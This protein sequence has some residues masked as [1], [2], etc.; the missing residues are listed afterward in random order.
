M[1][2]WPERFDSHSHRP[3]ELPVPS[4]THSHTPRHPPGPQ[5]ARITLSDRMGDYGGLNLNNANL[6]ADSSSSDE[7]LHPS[8]PTRPRHG[9]SMSQPFPSLFS[10][11]LRKAKQSLGGGGDD[12]DSDQ[13][14]MPKHKKPAGF[15]GHRPQASKDFATGHCMTCGSLVR[16][17]RELQVFKCTI[18]L[19]INDL[20]P[21]SGAGP[22]K[23]ASQRIPERAPQTGRERSGSILTDHAAGAPIS[24]EHTRSLIAECLQSYFRSALDDTEQGL[25]FQDSAVAAA[26]YSPEPTESPRVPAASLAVRPKP[27]G[28]STTGSPLT[29]DPSADPTLHPNPLRKVSMARSLS[30]SYPERRPSLHELAVHHN[31]RPQRR[32]DSPDSQAKHMFKQLEVYAAS[33]FSSFQC[34]NSSFSTHGLPIS[35]RP[36]GD[37]ARKPTIPQPEPRK[38]VPSDNYSIADLDPKLLLLGDFAE[39]GS[40]WTGQ[41]GRRPPARTASHRSQEGHPPGTM[42]S[43]HVDWTGLDEWYMTVIEA[44]RTWPQVYAD[45]IEKDMSLA[46]TDS[47]LREIEAQILAGQEHVQRTLLKA[48]ENLLKRPGRPI[49]EPHELRFLLIIAENPLL[50]SSDKLFKGQYAHPELPGGSG[51]GSG[52]AARGSGPVSGK[53]SGIIKRIL[54]LMSNSSVDCRAHLEAWFT[55]YP[56]SRFVRFKDLVS[57]FLNYR[58]IRENEKIHEVKVDV[59][60]GLI[61]SMS[62][63]RSPASLHAA[64]EQSAGS[65]RPSGSGMKKAK[66]AP[67]KTVYQ[68]NWQIR[69]AAKVMGLLFEANNTGCLR[70]T[71]GAAPEGLASTSRDLVQARGQRL[72]TS[73]FYMTLL[74]DSDLVADFEAWEQKRGKFSFCQFPFLLS[75]WAKIQILE[76]DAKRQMHNKARDA[77]FDSILTNRRIEQYLVISV[78]RECLVRDSL[79]AVSQVIS[80]GGEDIKKG[81]RVNFAGEEGVDA[82]GLRKEWFLLLIREVFN[83]EYGM[84][85]YDEDSQYCYFNPNS[86]EP[87]AQYNLVGVVFGLAI[88]NSTI[89]DVAFPPFAFRKLLMA[90][91]A[92]AGPTGS[93]ARPIMNY[94][95]DD[96]GEYRPRLAQSLR[97]LLEYDGDVESAFCLDF[98]VGLDRYGAQEAIPLCPGGEHRPVTN[99]NRR[100]FVDLYVRYLLDTSVAKQFE[101]FKRG[102]FTVCGGNALSLFRA[103]EIEL[104][105]R[106]SDE[107]LDIGSLKVAA[108]YENWGVPDPAHREP[109]VMWFWE[110][111]ERASPQDQRKLLSFITGSDRIPAMGAASLPIRISCLGEDCGRFPLARTCFNMLSLWRYRT[112]ERLEATL[113]RAVK[114]SEGFGL[115]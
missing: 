78:Q 98:T 47:R 66:E 111:F 83:P 8:R 95:L 43:P 52:S 92:P 45:L 81:L 84:F 62:M 91:P 10:G 20:Q 18:C 15:R 27:S 46:A 31:T 88:Y 85:V 29:S 108:Q 40:W 11:G 107:P 72:A 90:A 7:D 70:R 69:A 49:S 30:T 103:E 104:L 14:Q 19:T 101:P 109:T 115:K 79:E 42:K 21:G 12:S 74:D 54:G 93:Q 76:H 38:E 96:L 59:T 60:G 63:G 23:D 50:Y 99:A 3:A 44:A 86:F 67:P 37:S 56:Q 28:S 68:E 102:F 24:I 33:S 58:L 13:G 25:G 73:D 77:F 97:D 61:P 39:N 113:W 71:S 82:G 51:S 112:R 35:G 16:W 22:R 89:L 1:A 9:R 105:V 80:N 75:I 34:L 5:P 41:E 57:G 114:E 53:H 64:L 4:R 94:T 65:S 36:R 17:P 87:S 32:Q 48:T 100:E 106:G 110:T 6:Q 55:R 26:P 2:P